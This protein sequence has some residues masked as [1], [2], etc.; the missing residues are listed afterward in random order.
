M[1]DLNS[2]RGRYDFIIQPHRELGKFVTNGHVEPVEQFMSSAALRDPDF[3]PEEQLYQGLW[4]EIS[5]YDGKAYGFPF[6]ALTMY[7]WY[8]SD[9]LCGPEGEG[10]VQGQVRLR[11]RPGAGLEAV[12]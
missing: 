3:K 5:W 9:L 8:R 1:L 10:R 12:P 6:T 2:K 11:S 7:S 4:K